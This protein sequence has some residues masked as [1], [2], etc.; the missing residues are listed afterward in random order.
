MRKGDWWSNLTAAEGAVEAIDLREEH[1]YVVGISA[2]NVKRF[3]QGSLS[4]DDSKS[5][6]QGPTH[7]RPDPKPDLCCKNTGVLIDYRVLPII[8]RF[9]GPRQ[10]PCKDFAQTAT[11]MPRRGTG[12]APVMPRPSDP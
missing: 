4:P 8:D 10:V 9:I 5:A 11:G 7:R 2:G 3:D 6:T 12:M 1:H